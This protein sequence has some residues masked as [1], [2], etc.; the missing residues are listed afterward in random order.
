MVRPHRFILSS[1]PKNSHHWCEKSAD[2][3][4]NL[5]SEEELDYVFQK[6]LWSFNRMLWNIGVWNMEQMVYDVEKYREV[7]EWKDWQVNWHYD[8]NN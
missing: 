8:E 6:V 4:K 7:M 5:P 3:I 2:D 1:W